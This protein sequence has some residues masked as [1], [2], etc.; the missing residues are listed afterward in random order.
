[1]A[2]TKRVTLDLIDFGNTP[3]EYVYF[4]EGTAAMA[5]V[6]ETEGVVVL[7]GTGALVVARTAEHSLYLDGLGPLLGDYGSAHHV[8][9]MALRAASRS[10][11]HPRHFTE[12]GKAVRRQLGGREEDPRGHSL[13]P[14]SFSSY[15]RSDIAGLA[16]IVNAFAESGD[17]VA[18]QI[19]EEG[20][21]ALSETVFDVADRM[22]LI[23]KSFAMIGTGGQVS[24]NPRYWQMLCDKV[25]QFAPRVRP[26]LSDL[27][28]VIGIAIAAL[29]QLGE[30][31]WEQ[32]AERLRKTAREH[33]SENR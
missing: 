18:I 22:K 31:D 19:L 33:F 25:R 1:V 10:G 5:L 11:W 2:N 3:V 26:I 7:A 6:S 27:P 32:C 15:D 17:A 16:K 21:R 12:L 9:Y 23:D 8:G 28:P 13:V 4:D 30:P 14:F 24:R 29:R 20:A